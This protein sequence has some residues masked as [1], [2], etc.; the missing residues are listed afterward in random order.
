MC[1]SLSPGGSDTGRSKILM[2]E[3]FLLITIID[4]LQFE[5]S[6]DLEKVQL[7]KSSTCQKFEL[8]K[9][10]VYKSSSYPKFESTRKFEKLK[11]SEFL[12]SLV[13]EKLKRELSIERVVEFFE[14]LSLTKIDFFHY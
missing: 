3:Y 1:F 9:V 5:S 4:S 7:I 11:F 14:Y 12:Y 6:R 13:Q 8:T 10:Q 2:H